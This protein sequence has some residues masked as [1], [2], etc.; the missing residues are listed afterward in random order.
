MNPTTE[1]ILTVALLAIIVVC[2]G[3]SAVKIIKSMKKTN[4][5]AI[6]V[7]APDQKDF[8]PHPEWTVPD[9]GK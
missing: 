4:P 8:E 1:L 9:S 3:L 5:K 7:P 2:L 6:I